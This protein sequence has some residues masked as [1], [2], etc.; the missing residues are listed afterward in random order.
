MRAENIEVVFRIPIP[1]DRQDKNGVVYTKQAIEKV[2][3][4]VKDGKL[5][6]LP[7]TFMDNDKTNSVVIG[8]TH[9]DYSVEWD[10]ETQTCYLIAKGVIFAGGT[11]ESVDIENGKIQ[12]F[13]LNC[14]GIGR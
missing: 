4:D 13:S 11:H 1:I 6:G 9:N 10:Y 2:M 12:S 8:V 5:H 3:Q 7:I 14:V